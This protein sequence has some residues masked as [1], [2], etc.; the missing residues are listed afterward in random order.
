MQ[1]AVERGDCMCSVADFDISGVKALVRRT[2][3]T[4]RSDEESVTSEREL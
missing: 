2:A 3:V 1:P 4:G